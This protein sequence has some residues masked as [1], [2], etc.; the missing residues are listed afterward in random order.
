MKLKFGVWPTGVDRSPY[1]QEQE[2]Q[3]RR[4]S[5]L[6]LG[7]STAQVAEKTP[8][9]RTR[10]P[11][12]CLFL[13]LEAVHLVVSNGP[14]FVLD[15]GSRTYGGIERSCVTCR[16]ENSRSGGCFGHIPHVKNLQSFLNRPKGAI[17]GFSA[18]DGP[19]KKL[20]RK[21]PRSPSRGS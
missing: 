3:V 18:F 19:K 14:V 7:F 5:E 6:L 4:W 1:R 13:T 20:K 12:H 10:S 11:I 15:F 9:G 21:R 8:S 2:E 17:N 16:F